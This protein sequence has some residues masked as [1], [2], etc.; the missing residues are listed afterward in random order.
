MDRIYICPVC[1]DLFENRQ[2][3]HCMNCDSH[4]LE[5][6][7]C[8]YCYTDNPETFRVQPTT[9]KYDDVPTLCNWDKAHKRR[10]GMWT[11]Q[12]FTGGKR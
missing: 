1:A 12:A 5:E 10:R 3:R 2:V 9:L 8:K 7:Y 11:F 4:I 6:G